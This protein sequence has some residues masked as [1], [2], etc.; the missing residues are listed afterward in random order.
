MDGTMIDLIATKRI[1]PVVAIGKSAMAAELAASLI[2]GGLPIAEVTLRTPES[3][4]ALSIMASNKDL[5]VGVGSLR[6]GED[7]KKAIDAGAQFAVSAGFSPSVAS[8]AH[9]HGIQYFPGVSTPTEILQAISE[10]FTTLK[11]FPAETLGGVKALTAIAAPF[12]GI[13]FVPTG[14][15]SAANAPDYLSLASVVAVGGSWMVAQKLIDAGEFETIISLTQEAV[16]V[17]AK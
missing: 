13:R 2:A 10:G 17:C 3:L 11:F 5:V 7:L 1:I 6:N 12:P 4:E 16:E 14:G 15:I 9:K 8:E